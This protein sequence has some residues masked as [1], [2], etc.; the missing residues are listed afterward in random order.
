MP[1]IRKIMESMEDHLIIKIPKS[2][3]KRKLEVI[4]SPLNE[5][6]FSETSKELKKNFPSNLEALVGSFKGRLSSSLD[7]SQRKKIE[8]VLDL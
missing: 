4:V 8:K 5:E 2:F 1:G 6:D 3:L 7:F